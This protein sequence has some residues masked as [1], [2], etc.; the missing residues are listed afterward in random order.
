[1]NAEARRER[2]FLGFERHFW[3]EVGA[4][5]MTAFL[6]AMLTFALQLLDFQPLANLVAWEE[7]AYQSFSREIP[8]YDD[9]APPRPVVFIDIDEAA[10][11][12]WRSTGFTPSCSANKV[13]PKVAAGYATGS[14]PA[15]GTPR[16]L[17]AILTAAL[18]RAGVAVIYLDFDLRNTLPDDDLLAAE[19]QCPNVPVV[20]LPHIIASGPSPECPDD[21][22]L[23][24]AA[25]EIGTKFDEAEASG[26][27]GFVHPMISTGGDS[28]IGG[29]CQ[30]FRV[31]YVNSRPGWRERHGEWLPAAAVQAVAIANQGHFE[32]SHGT[33]QVGWREIR[34]WVDDTTTRLP[35]TRGRSP[36]VFFRVDVGLILDSGSIRTE[37]LGKSVLENAIAIVGATHKGSGDLYMTRLGTMPGA[38][39][40]ANLAVDLQ[41]R[42]TLQ[43]PSWVR[44]LIELALLF[45]FLFATTCIRRKIAISVLELPP[46]RRF[47]RRMAGILSEFAIMLFLAIV[48]DCATLLCFGGEVEIGSSWNFGI[49]SVVTGLCI[50]FTVQFISATSQAVEDGINDILV[51][52]APGAIGHGQESSA[53]I[54]ESSTPAGGALATM[55]VSVVARISPISEEGPRPH[56]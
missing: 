28:N 32:R 43:F 9:A 42:S 41:A 16:G 4:S 31:R 38:L 36:L 8:H 48:F 20:L 53:D 3:G 15:S 26:S 10:V 44:F 12:G 37:L 27:V 50:A 7:Q 30:S 52:S 29:I 5:G 25:T 18:R 19:L 24:Q 6:I 35:A 11:R 17:I 2:V 39:V 51:G 13:E 56:D 14:D 34:W 1:M 45:V 22:N 55:E 23:K 54:D 49:T 33:P 21:R 40:H 47:A 46:S